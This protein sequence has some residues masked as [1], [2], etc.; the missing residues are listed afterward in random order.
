M[1]LTPDDIRNQ[2]FKTKLKGFDKE[3]VLMYLQLVAD[4]LEFYQGENTLLKDQLKKLID[5]S[6]K[7]QNHIKT[8]SSSKKYSREE[9]LTEG[10]KIIQKA[11]NRARE[12]K[13]VTENEAYEMEKKILQLEAR[14]NKLMKDVK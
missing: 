4:D 13:K 8:Q 12:I 3:D 5:L 6:E 14:K 9:A 1:R 10:E 2:Q 11:R 7:L